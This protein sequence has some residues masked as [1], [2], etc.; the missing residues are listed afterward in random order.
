MSRIYTCKHQNKSKNPYLKD[1][2]CPKCGKASTEMSST[3]IDTPIHDNSFTKFCE[4][5]LGPK[6]SEDIHE[7]KS[8][9]LNNY[10]RETVNKAEKNNNNRQDNTDKNALPQRMFSNFKKAVR[11]ELELVEPHIMHSNNVEVIL[12]KVQTLESMGIIELQKP[13]ENADMRQIKPPMVNTNCNICIKKVFLTKQEFLQAHGSKID[14]IPVSFRERDKSKQKQLTEYQLINSIPQTKKDNPIFKQLYST[15]LQEIAKQLDN[16]PLAKKK[17]TRELKLSLGRGNNSITVKIVMERNLQGNVRI[18]TIKRKNSR[19][20]A[21]FSCD[22]IQPQLLPNTNQNIGIDV[23]LNKKSYIT[24]SNGV[25]Y[26]H[27]QHYKKVEKKLIE[28]QK[29][30][31][32][33]VNQSKHYFYQ[34][35]NDLV[36]NYDGIAIEDLKIKNIVRNHN[37][38]KSIQQARNT[39]QRCSDCGNLAK[40]KVKLSQRLYQCFNCN[41]KLDRDVNS[42]KNIL[43]LGF[44]QSPPLG[45]KLKLPKKQ[46]QHLTYLETISKRSKEFIIKEALIQYL[47]YAEDVAEAYAEERKK[48][49]KDCT[50]EDMLEEINLKEINVQNKIPLLEQENKQIKVQLTKQKVLLEQ[51]LA[52][53]EE[54]NHINE[55]KEFCQQKGIN[56]ELYSSSLDYSQLHK[57]TNCQIANNKITVVLEDRREISLPLDLVIKE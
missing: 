45:I 17:E 19:Y 21:C 32:K 36:K 47:K 16:S 22:N 57:I 11:G 38:A 34:A 28:T 1:K 52:S 54:E 24:L 3:L 18:L 39:T 29:K 2:K 7:C 40:G 25:K 55:I 37:L 42:A 8:N 14:F 4:K 53:Y 10:I 13:S 15:T 5:C 33:V 41:L 48:G 44:D 50:T 12:N 51:L 31:K 43:N 6:T 20:Y 23:N 26:K 27:P 56:Y 49:A 46:E 35:A 30:L 9:N